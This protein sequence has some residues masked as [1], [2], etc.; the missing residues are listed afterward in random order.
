MFQL[1]FLSSLQALCSSQGG[2]APKLLFNTILPLL[3]GKEEDLAPEIQQYLSPQRSGVC[4]YRSL[5]AFLAGALPAEEYKKFKFEYKLSLLDKFLPQLDSLAKKKVHWGTYWDTV[6]DYALLKRCLEKFSNGIA[7]LSSSL[8]R[9]EL[10]KAQLKILETNFLLQKLERRLLAYEKTSLKAPPSKIAKIN[11]VQL[12]YPHPDVIQEPSPT[13]TLP[14][15]HLSS[16]VKSA[17][18]SIERIPANPQNPDFSKTVE[19]SLQ[20]LQNRAFTPEERWQ[21]LDTFFKK[22]G[23]FEH[24]SQLKLSQ[25]QKAL[26]T[27]HL[28][29]NQLI[30]SSDMQEMEKYL[31]YY[32]CY[33]L[34]ECA[35]RQLP[36]SS[37]VLDAQFTTFLKNLDFSIFQYATCCDPFWISRFNELQDL[38]QKERRQVFSLPEIYKN[39]ASK[40]SPFQLDVAMSKAIVSWWSDPDRPW[41]VELANAHELRKEHQKQIADLSAKQGQV[42]K[43]IQDLKAQILE[44][45]KTLNESESIQKTAILKYEIAKKHSEISQ[46]LIE[47]SLVKE[48]IFVDHEEFKAAWSDLNMPDENDLK[49]TVLILGKLEGKSFQSISSEKDLEFIQTLNKKET[50]LQTLIELEKNSSVGQLKDLELKLADKQAEEEFHQ[51]EI[52]QIKSLENQKLTP[53]SISL[54]QDRLKQQTDA[55][56]EIKR[57]K[58]GALGLSLTDKYL[59]TDIKVTQKLEEIFKEKIDPPILSKD[60]VKINLEATDRYLFMLKS[61]LSQKLDG[62]FSSSLTPKCMGLTETQKQLNELMKQLKEPSNT[63]FKDHISLQIK[64]LEAR[65][66]KLDLKAEYWPYEWEKGKLSLQGMASYLF[67]L[68]PDLLQKKLNSTQEII[69]SELKQLYQ[70]ALAVKHL[71]GKKV[72]LS[73]GIPIAMDSVYEQKTTFS[74]KLLIKTNVF[75][76]PEPEDFNQY[77]KF[78]SEFK[79]YKEKISED[80]IHYEF[81]KIYDFDGAAA[82]SYEEYIDF[83][84]LQQSTIQIEATLDYFAEHSDLLTKPEWVEA[85]HDLLFKKNLL[86]KELQD[87]T[88]NQKVTARF[89]NFFDRLM[90]Q[91]ERTADFNLLGNLLWTKSL[92]QGYIDHVNLTSSP[93]PP[94]PDLFSPTDISDSIKKVLETPI[95]SDKLSILFEACTAASSKCNLKN[96]NPEDLGFI[97]LA[98]V[99]K[100]SF[101]V[102]KNFVSLR[103]RDSEKAEFNIQRFFTENPHLKASDF[104]QPVHLQALRKLYSNIET[105]VQDPLQPDALVNKDQSLRICFSAGRLQ[106]NDPTLLHR[107]ENPLTEVQKQIFKEC[108]LFTEVNELSMLRCSYNGQET[109][110]KKMPDGPLFTLRRAKWSP[111]MILYLKIPFPDGTYHWGKWMSPGETSSYLQNNGIPAAYSCFAIL[112][113]VPATTKRIMTR[114]IHSGIV[115]CDKKTFTPRYVSIENPHI[116]S[117]T[118]ENLLIDINTK[119]TLVKPSETFSNF[120]DMNFTAFWADDKKSL[121]KIDFP[122]FNLTFKKLQDRF[123]CEQHPG[124]HLDKEQFAPI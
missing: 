79:K 121:Q 7:N 36:E 101:P 13:A 75:T 4:T 64:E 98:N 74:P 32:A 37:R 51:F 19:A 53:L 116:Q 35:F 65:P 99:L 80:L 106:S 66:N 2:E 31:L 6:R 52:N 109:F 110:I 70:H 59:E 24:I 61:F 56:V 60:S 39:F 25:P 87:P 3:G 122:R 108:G 1:P 47:K 54:Y 18:E 83:A 27:L 55:Q 77:K 5:Q 43:E 41:N 72:D 30:S 123:E 62:L 69:P 68:K 93:Q 26:D 105:L 113:D 84:S 103:T 117:P 95:N 118:E 104:F 100:N 29:L 85:F 94:L 45:Q 33:A 111:M 9:A 63:R 57:L 78:A 102:Q 90:T 17:L 44:Q 11:A 71:P 34:Y 96:C 92:V 115:V 88:L 21:L 14:S 40:V 48:E 8:D 89:S 86:L 82:L 23:S 91:A 119:H 114:D 16:E 120:E 38:L 20:L 46:L 76:E 58:R 42:Q 22:I 112:S 73:T 107:Y 50:E 67:G 124:W 15:K 49:T 10:E 97:L 12:P 81:S 28:I